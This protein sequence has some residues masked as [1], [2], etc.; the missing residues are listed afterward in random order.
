[1]PILTQDHLT[2]LNDLPLILSSLL[3]DPSWEVV[4]ELFVSYLWVST[5][6][7]YNWATSLAVGKSSPSSQPI[8]ES[9]KDMAAFLLQVMHS[10]CV[11]L[12]D[13]LPLE[14]QL[15][16]CNMLVT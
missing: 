14:K 4:A 11:C 2:V 12:K 16:L 9:K 7:I 13:Y 3:S 8:Q 10:T 1:M 15:K 5:E 6:R